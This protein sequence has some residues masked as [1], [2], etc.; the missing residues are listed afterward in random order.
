MAPSWPPPPSPPPGPELLSLGG[1]VLVIGAGPSGLV[2]LKTLLEQGYEATIVETSNKV[3][4][5]FANK[6]YDDGRLVSSKFLTP[7]SDLRM[8]D[9][10]DHPTIPE[11]VRY[12]ER[13]C[14]HFKLWERIRFGTEVVRVTRRAVSSPDEKDI[15]YDVDVRDIEKNTQKTENFGAVCVC[16][17]LHNVPEVPNI[18]GLAENFKGQVLHS[19]EYR[20]KKIF[21]GK[22]VLVIGTGETG[23]DISYRAIQVTDNVRLCSR[24]G[25]LSVPYVIGNGLPLDTFITNLCECSHLH[26]LLERLKVKWLFTTPFIRLGFLLGTGSSV[27]YN[28]W[29]GGKD[30][31]LVQRGWLIINKSTDA[32]PFINRAVKPHSRVGSWL[33]GWLDRGPVP[34]RLPDRCIKMSKGVRRVLANGAVE[35]DDGSQENFDTIVFATGYR[36]SFPFLHETTKDK[37]VHCDGSGF[38]QDALPSE[39]NIVNPNEPKLA[40]LGFVRPNVGAIPPM[41][42]LQIMWWIQRLRGAIPGPKAPPTYR[43]LGP[44]DR[45]GAYGVDYGSY[46]HDLARDIGAE[47]QIRDLAWRSPKTLVAWALGQAYI[48]F[49][50]LRGPFVQKDAIAISEGELL[51]PVLRRPLASNLLFVSLIGLFMCLNG[52]AMLVSPFVD[53]FRAVRSRSISSGK[54][55]KEAKLSP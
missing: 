32:M 4:G 10:D 41:S 39:H 26:P 23:L 48:T 8:E 7:F 27:G 53:L 20:E 51:S 21:E 45:T 47:P 22:R 6:S 28:Q 15:S 29:A 40:Y 52:V 50:R 2:A 24:S 5:T 12:L 38:K 13:Y 54:K 35:L 18:P 44:N 42:E 30:S 36:V 1:K 31:S 34:D 14:T 19:S 46:M 49:F 16:S 43:L 55:G 3:G 33:Y 9:A 11:Y 17:G 25:F 37:T